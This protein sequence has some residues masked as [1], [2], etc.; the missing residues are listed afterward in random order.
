M[1]ESLDFGSVAGN[2]DLYPDRG[3]FLINFTTALLG[4][5]AVRQHAG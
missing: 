1:E 5:A 2:P 4:S 3:I